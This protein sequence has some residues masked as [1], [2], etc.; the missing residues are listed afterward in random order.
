MA[1]RKG[2]KTGR[3]GK[4]RRKMI[5]REIWKKEEESGE[6]VERDKKRKCEEKGSKPRRRRR[7]GSKIITGLERTFPM[8][9]KSHETEN[10]SN[11]TAKDQTPSHIGTAAIESPPPPPSPEMVRTAL[12][13]FY[14]QHPAM[15]QQ[16]DR[17][18]LEHSVD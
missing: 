4:T 16:E 17:L 15:G 10:I 18:R 6:I 14:L 12:K 5:K 3:K 7:K 11:G 1:R 2:M 8:L 13:S 9:A